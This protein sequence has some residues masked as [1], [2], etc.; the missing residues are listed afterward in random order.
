MMQY[1]QGITR[2]E[3][4]VILIVSLIITYLVYKNIFFVIDKIS[5]RALQKRNKILHLLDLMFIEMTEKKATQVLTLMT[6]GPGFLAFMI[7]WPH[8]WLGLVAGVVASMGGW[9]LP[10]VIVKKM[11]NKRCSYLVGQMIDGLTIM[12][13]GIKAGLTVPQTMERVVENMNGPIRQEFSLVL[14]QIRLGRSVE[15]ALI[16]F[17]ERIPKSDVQMFVTAINILK[18]T[19]GNL[20]ETLGTIVMVIRERQ[21]VEKRI[22]AMTAQGRIQGLIVSLVPV[23]LMLL[24]LVVDSSFVM[25]FFTMPLGWALLMAIIGLITIGSFVIKKI[26]TIDV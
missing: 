11:Y 23:A 22:E 13:N 9:F 18:E 20:T 17:G 8:L 26:V 19:G 21:K 5:R 7:M 4:F 25:P 15:E 12:R 16:E 24:F 3:F 1:W 14:S 6:L 10:L 2:S